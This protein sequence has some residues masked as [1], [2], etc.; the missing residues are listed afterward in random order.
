MSLLSACCSLWLSASTS[1]ILLLLMH[2]TRL[3]NSG[4]GDDSGILDRKMGVSTDFIWWLTAWPCGVD[5]ANPDDSG[6]EVLRV[7]WFEATTIPS[8]LVHF[9]TRR[10]A[11]VLIISR[12]TQSSIS[13]RGRG[14]E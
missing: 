8:L 14:L 12:Q 3:A 1:L 6:G 9:D 4:T 5:D 10:I 2:Q 7:E 11:A 13:H